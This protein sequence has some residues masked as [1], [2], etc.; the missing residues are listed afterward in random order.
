MGGKL[1]SKGPGRSILVTDFSAA[2]AWLLDTLSRLA[3]SFTDQIHDQTSLTEDGLGLDSVDLLELVGALEE[4]LGV[5][6]T[7][8]DIT[9]EH[10]G[11][12][13]RLL[14]FLAARQ[15]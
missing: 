8:D 15:S 1:S 2:R 13:E 14:R 3:P 6:I 11:T 10:F 9:P 5:T 4:G 12:V 7:E